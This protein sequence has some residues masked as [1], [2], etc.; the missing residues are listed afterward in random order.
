[1]GKQ[2][3]NGNHKTSNSTALGLLAGGKMK[4][5]NAPTNGIGL[6]VEV[7]VDLFREKGY[8]G[9]SMRD[10]A[11]NVGVLPGSLYAHIEGK[12]DILSRIVQLSI[13]DFEMI[14]ETVKSY[15][16]SPEDK[17]RK[18]I[19]LH[20]QVVAKS[21]GRILVALHQWR[22]LS[23]PTLSMAAKTRRDY[24][25]MYVDILSERAGS[26]NDVRTKMEAYAI[27]GAI[28]WAPEWFLPDGTESPELV[29]EILADS[30]ILGL[31]R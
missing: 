6:I 9:T 27:L 7:S 31:G 1:M 5:S 25:Q 26:D 10:I 29:G 30:L 13:E 14:Q 15:Q 24:T 4:A 20:M 23:E 3:A 18:A 19:I 12:K 21:P 2:G 11:K 28:Y 8:S 16:A 22:F 17:L